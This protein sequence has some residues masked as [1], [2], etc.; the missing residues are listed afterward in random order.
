MQT[1]N[2]I[3]QAN[4]ER[5]NN[6]EGLF[7]A[8]SNT[9]LGEGLAKFG[10][11]MEDTNQ[12]VSIGAGGY[13]LKTRVKA[14]T[15]MMGQNERDLKNLRKEK[16]LLLDALVYELRNHE[17]CITGDMTDALDALGL[18]FEDVPSDILKKAHKLTANEG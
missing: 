10:L 5:V 6:F 2:D 15:E 3:K 4:Q 11:T 9:Q 14:F 1:Y 8:F 12:I 16:K 7:F 17:Y 18:K 13:L